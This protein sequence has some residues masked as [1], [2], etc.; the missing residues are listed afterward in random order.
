[1]YVLDIKLKHWALCQ[2]LFG[3]LSKRC[4]ARIA[5]GGG[6][7]KRKTLSTAAVKPYN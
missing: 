1:M 4:T 5:K 6:L 7:W 3:I 2:A